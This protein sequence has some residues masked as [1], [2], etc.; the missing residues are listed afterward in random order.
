MTRTLSGFV[1]PLLAAL[2]ML[3]PG[4]AVAGPPE[5]LSRKMTLAADDVLTA[6]RKAR[7]EPDPYKRLVL[8]YD[9]GRTRDPRIAVGVCEIMMISP[10]FSDAWHDARAALRR[11]FIEDDEEPVLWWAKNEAD[12]RRRAARLPR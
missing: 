8:L 11:W 5:R 12:L 1:S 9:Q 6:L 4:K 10:R 7:R 2:L 3:S